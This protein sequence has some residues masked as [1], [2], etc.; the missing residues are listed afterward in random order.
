MAKAWIPVDKVYQNQ[1]P[2]KK[3]TGM[4]AK[5]PVQE[6]VNEE[7]S[8]L[9]SLIRGGARTATQGASLLAGAAGDVP[10]FLLGAG[11][12]ATGG[13]IPSYQDVKK[14]SPIP[15][16]P[17]SQE[18]EEYIGEKTGGYTNPQSENEELI[19][20]ILKTI[21]SFYLPG[22]AAHG[23][24]T[25]LSKVIS[26]SKAKLASKIILP[27][28]GKEVSFK[29]AAATGL[30]GEAVGK[31]VETV[32]G[33]KTLGDAAKF[34]TMVFAQTAG[35]KNKLENTMTNS[36]DKAM[37]AIKPGA[38]ITPQSFV[39]VSS[40]R[41]K[42]KNLIKEVNNGNNPN[43]DIALTYLTG[44]E[45]SLDAMTTT[46]GK[47]AHGSNILASELLQLKRDTNEW[48]KL[49]SRP[50]VP[51]EKHL[52]RGLR[53]Y[54]ERS[55][56]YIKEPLEEFG[57]KN[58]AF[59]EAFDVGEDIF[60][61]L[62]D[63][64]EATRFLKD[65]VSLKGAMKSDIAKLGLWGGLSYFAGAPYGA[66]AVGGAKAIREAAL[67]KNLFQKSKNAKTF[68]V[69]ALKQASKDNLQGFLRSASKLDK[70]AQNL[71]R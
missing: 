69:D 55:L 50:S 19:G 35:G 6:Q 1:D 49:S 8:P 42:I 24:A 47:S 4:F 25:G 7:E 2:L 44:L 40:T 10:S 71:Y 70:V 36:Y 23:I 54:V 60:T 11:N 65:N 61:G 57:K 17:T 33:S 48:M 45:D 31:G 39:N 67:V 56:G 5:Q 41:S 68:Y 9:G 62:T 22:K 3:N 37:E 26:P 34:G 53:K 14:K 20:D 63:L 66:A 16:P 58:P 30:G 51:G 13:A 28:A 15:L 64:D 29:R 46:A 43:K 59:K 27:F 32:T 52:P 18:V 21:G 12:W 38:V